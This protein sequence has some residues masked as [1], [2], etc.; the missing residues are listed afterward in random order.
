MAKP[1]KKSADKNMKALALDIKI[2]KRSWKLVDFN[3]EKI[4][5]AVHKALTASGQGDGP[6]SAKLTDKVVNLIK[7]RF[8]KEESIKVEEIQDIVEEAL[9]LENYIDTAKA[10]I[11]YREQH[12][13]IREATTTIDEALDMVDNY[14]KDADWQVR[15]NSNMGYSLQG[16]HHYLV[17]AV[18]KKYWMS[19]IYPKEIRDGIKKGSLHIHDL[20]FLGPYCCGWDLHDLLV[21]GFGGVQGKVESSPAKHFRTALGQLVNF[22]YTLQGE[23]AGAQAVSN[24]DTLLAPFIR[25]DNL[26]YKQVRQAIQEF[27]FNCAIPTRVGFQTPF[28]NVTLD[29]TPPKHLATQSVI[30][31]GKP[32]DETYGDFQEEMNL[33]NKAFAEVMVEGDSKGRIFTFPIPTINITKDFDWDNPALENVWEMT[34]KYGVPYFANFINSDIS[35]DDARSMCCRL[36]LDNR[37]LY[38]RGGGLFGSA[39]LTG[40]IGVV[41]IN[42]PQIAYLS[43]TK[44]DFFERLNVLMDLARDGLE[45]KRKTV[46]KYIESGLYPYSKHYLHSAKQMRDTYWGN[47]F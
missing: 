35:P 4:K 23:S 11:L 38:K 37:E 19:K 13:R 8:K 6:E 43:K 20:D 3:P 14:I 7:K 42:L 1:T 41:T 15:E 44:K 32:Q 9:I 27:V 30:I 36:R 47:H 28:L 10:Y 2:E 18:S 29:I 26:T 31:G 12:R 45:I 22:F 40:S 17:A 34:A 5:K 16:L 33:F 39:P 46:D 24:F 25:H 21:R